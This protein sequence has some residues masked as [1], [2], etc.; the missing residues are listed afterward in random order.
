MA[1]NK[2][3]TL[4]LI[5]ANVLHACFRDRVYSSGM[6]M[7]SPEFVEKKKCKCGEDSD[8]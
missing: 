6:T 4:D 7:P 3:E 5:T 8:E 1:A 2:H